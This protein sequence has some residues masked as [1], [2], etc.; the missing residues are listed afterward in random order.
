M[1]TKK[2]KTGRDRSHEEDILKKKRS[3][4]YIFRQL[5]K[6]T[7][8]IRTEYYLKQAKTKTKVFET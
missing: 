3:N 6:S 1:I 5:R 4:M 7:I 8:L 2:T